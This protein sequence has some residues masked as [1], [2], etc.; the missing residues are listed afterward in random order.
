MTERRNT[1]GL[2]KVAFT[3]TG[4]YVIVSGQL[5]KG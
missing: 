2:F 5:Q 1:L 4:G 3:K